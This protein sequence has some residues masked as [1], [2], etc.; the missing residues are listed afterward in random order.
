MISYYFGILVLRNNLLSSTNSKLF[1][2]T[3]TYFKSGLPFQRSWKMCPGCC[4]LFYSRGITHGFFCLWHGIQHFFF[5]CIRI[6][7]H[8]LFF[9]VG[10]LGWFVR[11]LCLLKFEYYKRPSPW[12]QCVLLM[13][14]YSEEIWVTKSVSLIFS[15]ISWHIF[16]KCYSWQKIW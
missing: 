15:Q 9:W 14:E 16:F 8:I 10:I 3:E 6:A 11:D 1:I 12:R 5:D 4:S 2:G 7:F 13:F